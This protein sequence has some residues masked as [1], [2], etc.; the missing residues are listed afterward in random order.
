MWFI[1]NDCQV[2]V[3]Y[4]SCL[5]LIITLCEKFAMHGNPSLVFTPQV[6]FK[7]FDSSPRKKYLICFDMIL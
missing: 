7:E 1:S 5:P 4:M 6:V 3:S 2:L